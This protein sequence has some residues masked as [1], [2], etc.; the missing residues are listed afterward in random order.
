MPA[1]VLLAAGESRRLG[2][3][4]ALVR[5]R[6]R[7]PATPLAFLLAAGACLDEAPPLVV[8]GAH[9][10]EI[11]DALPPGVELLENPRWREGR[12]GGIALAARHRPGL[13]LCLAPVDVPAVGSE[14]FAALA[15]AWAGAGAPARGW[16]APFV[17]GPQGPPRFGHPVLVGRELLSELAARGTPRRPL[18]SLREH[19]GPLLACPV[20]SAAILDDLD[21]PDDLDRIRARLAAEAAG[22]GPDAPGES[23]Q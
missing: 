11:G 6:E 5:L 14:V 7:E 1:L 16:L 12:T 2:R 15:A 3:P 23:P 17:E 8:A 13:D 22:T 21:T 9:A 10:S 20:A 18:R 19:A 4:K